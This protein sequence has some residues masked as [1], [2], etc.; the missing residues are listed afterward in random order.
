MTPEEREAAYQ[1][2][3]TPGQSWVVDELRLIRCEDDAVLVLR[4]TEF[5]HFTPAGKRTEHV[6]HPADYVRLAR[7]AFRLPAL[8]MEEGVRAWAALAG[9]SPVVEAVG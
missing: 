1:R 8:P 9:P 7:E 6:A 2:H 3:H 4:G 5:S